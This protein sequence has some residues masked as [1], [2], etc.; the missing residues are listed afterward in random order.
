MKIHLNTKLLSTLSQVLF[1]PSAEL[2]TATGIPT[3]TWYYCMGKPDKITI[4]FLLS[5]ANGLNIPVRK[6]FSTENT[7]IIGRRE[8]Y[9][10][11]PYLPCYYDEAALQRYFAVSHEATWQ[12]AS[13][14]AN[15]TP[16]NLRRSLLAVTRLPVERFL[17]VCEAFDIDP[18]TILIDPNPGT[19]QTPNK[20]NKRDTAKDIEQLRQQI[21]QLSSDIADLTKKY[22]DLRL[23]YEDMSHQLV[24]ESPTTKYNKK[25]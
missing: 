21:A 25:K 14:A 8:D 17:V 11:E 18:F 22:D 4:D 16:T 7:D 13:L 12:R 19:T 23:F 2:R 5:I 20:P 9:I 6:F 10:A 15:V 24:A 1:L 3:S